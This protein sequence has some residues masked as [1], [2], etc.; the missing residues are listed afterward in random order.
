MLY[1]GKALSL[2]VRDDQIAEL[3][4][5][6]T[7][8]SVNKFSG[9]VVEELSQ[10]IAA[11]EKNQDVKGLLVTSGKGV[12][13]VGADI[14]E[15]GQIFGGGRSSTEQMVSGNNNNLNRLEALSIPTVVAINGYALGG[16]L[17]FCLA[18]D[19]RVAS[20]A[21]KIGLPEVSLGLIPSWGGTV[22]L[23][24]IADAKTALEW[25]GS[26]AHYAAADAEKVGV[27]DRAAEPDALREA[28]LEVLKAAMNGE[29]DYRARRT[30]K[31]SPVAADKR[32]GLEE[33]KASKL[34]QRIM[35]N[36]NYPA[37]I[38]ALELIERAMDSDRDQALAQE[39]EV[40]I[41]L[42]LGSE[43]HALVNM[44]LNDQALSKK[45]KGWEK[46]ADRKITQ[47]G[48]LGAGIMGGGIAYQS[49]LKGISTR[50]KD[51]AQAG[52]DLGMKEARALL[53]KRV[54][55]GAMTAEKM[56]QI[57]GNIEPTLNY[58][59][60]DKL[61]IVVEAVVE[62][63]GVKHQVLKE[64]EEVVSPDTVLASN[65]STISID[66]LAQVLKRPE[67]FCGMHFFNPVHAMPL[68]EV[69]RGEKT[70][71][72]AIART[73]AYA[74]AMGKKAVVVKDCPGFL[75]NRV[76]F[77]YLA[78]FSTLL[79]DGA[80]FREIDR[81]MTEWGWP[82]GPAY[83]L[84]VIGIDT[85]AHAIKIMADSYPDRMKKDFKD[86]IE[87]LYEA[88]RYGQKNGKGFYEYPDGE[89][90]KRVDTGE[91]ERLLAEH[92][93]PRRSFSDEEIIARMMVPM[94][95]EMARCLDE[96][97]VETPAEADIALIYGLGFPTFRGGIFSWLDNMGV[98]A[99]CEMA[100]PYRDLGVLYQ[101]TDSMREK[102]AKGEKYL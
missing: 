70:S 9:S 7:D 82:M 54:D 6:A 10:A 80:D 100:E 83:L 14:T 96:Q 68:V 53:Q 95:T 32:G 92:V 25:I 34:Y 20:T 77:P 52:L 49:A 12:F 27:V 17:E 2:V 65:T 30:Q 48:V 1:E 99:F 19:Y 58:D 102:A 101:S 75:V 26:G 22:R 39:A 72:A 43:A 98:A 61:D 29:L 18:C 3:C 42:A 85:A 56:E 36:R 66:F 41:D 89:K 59:G 64:V 16:G 84:D 79:R 46:R 63:P 71:E 97:I 5:D 21:A 62:N 28:A 4:F 86:C 69:V 90:G 24:R 33:F 55:R 78:G 93:Q 13:I 37:P 88:G 60:F 81:V 15:F 51:I 50:M 87:V 44:F 76:F 35:A 74:N 91:A 38:R 67:N 31:L 73:V 57:L 11:L 45:A 40:F 94:A 23:P 8:G 47:A